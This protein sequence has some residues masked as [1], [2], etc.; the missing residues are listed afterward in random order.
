MT[1]KEYLS[2]ISRFDIMI[3]NKLS[4]YYQINTLVY[5]VSSPVAGDKVQTSAGTDK[6]SSAVVKMV[7]IEKSLENL[8][9]QR[10]KIVSEIQE[11]DNL[12]FCDVLTKRYVLGM[13]NKEIAY[14]KNKGLRTV[15]RYIDEAH[16]EF[17]R[18]FGG[19]WR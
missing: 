12:D 1:T 10:N 14:E 17:E 8:T 6:M 13:T 3:Q 15:E 16:R 19:D 9:A 5:S 18:K 11:I 7:D 4:E 2:R